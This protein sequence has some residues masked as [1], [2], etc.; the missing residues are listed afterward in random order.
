M[1]HIR[2]ENGYEETIHE[3]MEYMIRKQ[4]LD[5]HKNEHELLR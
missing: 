5:D 3:G 1:D 4:E 2:G